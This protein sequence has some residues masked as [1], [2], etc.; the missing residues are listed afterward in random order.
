MSSTVSFYEKGPTRWLAVNCTDMCSVVCLL[1]NYLLFYF[2]F[3]RIEL[4]LYVRPLLTSQRGSW[5]A[6]CRSKADSTPYSETICQTN[7][8][9]IHSSLVKGR[10][11]F[12]KK[13]SKSLITESDDL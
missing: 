11:R 8:H 1:G 5:D 6:Y 3:E 9:I 12:G 2:S 7:I 10:T 13:A 4:D